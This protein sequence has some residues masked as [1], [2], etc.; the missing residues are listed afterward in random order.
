MKQEEFSY[1]FFMRAFISNSSHRERF[2]ALAHARVKV[3]F[4]AVGTA[5]WLVC[6]AVGYGHVGPRRAPR[7]LPLAAERPEET[8]TALTHARP[9]VAELLARA[10][11]V[12]VVL[13]REA[14]GRHRETAEA[15]Q[16]YGSPDETHYLAHETKHSER[17]PFAMYLASSTSR[18]AR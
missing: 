12:A 15:D 2:L 13:A 3:A 11:P 17:E 1:H 7:A 16:Q 14:F 18:F 4:A 5:C 9:V 8:V 6:H 10:V